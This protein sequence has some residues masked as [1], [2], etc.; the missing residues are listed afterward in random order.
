MP[1][2]FLGAAWA[3][4]WFR[5]YNNGSARLDYETRPDSRVFNVAYLNEKVRFDVEAAFLERPSTNDSL[6]PS[7]T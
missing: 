1:F 7:L 4:G 2:G 6:V 3:D 5:R